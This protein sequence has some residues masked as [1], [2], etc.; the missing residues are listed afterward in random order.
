MPDHLGK[1]ALQFRIEPKNC[2]HIFDLDLSGMLSHYLTKKHWTLVQWRIAQAFATLGE[3]SM[4][5]LKSCVISGKGVEG[6][7]LRGYFLLSKST[8]R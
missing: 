7:I 1:E 4:I 2:V 3:L 8:Q 6:L 5:N